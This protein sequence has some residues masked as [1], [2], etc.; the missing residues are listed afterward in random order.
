MTG[1]TNSLSRYSTPSAA[2][3]RSPSRRSGRSG[4]KR[5]SKGEKT[6][7]DEH[8]QVKMEFGDATL[9]TLQ[10]AENRV[11]GGRRM[12]KHPKWL[13]SKLMDFGDATLAQ[14]EPKKRQIGF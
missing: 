5:G 6:S 10:E 9:K 2:S 7:T 4:S 12:R 8:S 13:I 3:W 14:P 1:T 11:Q